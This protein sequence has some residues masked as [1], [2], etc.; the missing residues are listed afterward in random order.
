MKNITVKY[1]ITILQ[2]LKA[3][4]KLAEKCLLVI[5]E[6][7]KLL[8]TLTDGDLRRKI[9]MGVKFS[10]NISNSYKN[11]PIVFVQN[12]YTSDEVEQTLRDKKIDLIPVIDKEGKVVDYLTWSNNKSDKQNKKVLD[13]VSVVIMAGGK[14]TRMEPFTNVLPKPLIPIHGKPIIE[15]IIERFTDMGC[16]DFHLTV[17]YK[18]KILKAYFEELNPDYTLSFVDETEPLGTA[19]SLQYLN[20]KFN[21]PFFVTNCDIIIKADYGNLYEFHK[22]GGY[23]ITLVASAKEYV[24]PYGTCELNSEGYFSHINEKPKYDFLINSG[25]YILNPDVLSIIP[26]N[27]FYHITHMIEKLKNAKKDI[28]VF[29]IDDDA[30]I[31]IGQWA[32][33]K[34]AVDKL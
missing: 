21:K 18:S 27:K 12:K 3:L 7:G 14:G 11:N 31:D 17:N 15:H 16:S 25:L 32:E 20:G 13:D 2:A 23:D 1:D 33:Y 30:W 28:G 22:K 4:D 19:G 10:E 8:G 24:I 29:P 26:K 34:K 6:T 9:L 5:D